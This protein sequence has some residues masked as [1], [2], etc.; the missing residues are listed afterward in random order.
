MKDVKQNKE[1]RG[2]GTG[3]FLQPVAFSA[4]PGKGWTAFLMDC[5]LLFFGLFGAAW[6]F[7]SAF[8][9]PIDPIFPLV[10]AA[11]FAL[12]FTAAYRWRFADV[13]LFVLAA[14][15]CV[16]LWRFQ[17]EIVQGFLVAAN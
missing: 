17:E 12:L 9:L 6:A 7:L 1:A 8:S 15:L 4:S 3:L 16:F 14:G 10:L 11:S 2:A 13:I 5:L